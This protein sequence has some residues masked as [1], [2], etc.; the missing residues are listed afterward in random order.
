MK[1]RLKN[2]IVLIV[3]CMFVT[4]CYLIR[5]NINDVKVQEL[6]SY[7]FGL[8]HGDSGVISQ[9]KYD[10]EEIRIAYYVEGRAEG[11]VSEFAWFAFVDGLP[12]PTQLE[13]ESGEIIRQI[14]YMHQF[15]LEF[16]ERL[17][18][19]IVFTPVSG[20]NGET[21]DFIVASLLQPDYL[22]E[23][24]DEPIFGVFHTLGARFPEEIL[25]NDR[26]QNTLSNY[27]NIQLIEVPQNLIDEEHSF[28]L[29]DVSRLKW[30]PRIEILPAEADLQINYEDLI[31][32]NNG[33]VQIQ[34]LLYGGPEAVSRI[35]FFVNHQ[36][37][38]VNGV[39]FIEIQMESGQMAL[40]QVELTLTEL[41]DFNSLY[42]IVAMPNIDH[43]V[44]GI[45][46]TQT[47]L[48]VSQ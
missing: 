28:S 33:Y 13:F 26:I 5:G 11:V 46:K 21:V 38:A 35:T 48:L 42:A 24:R 20:E 29:E 47:L 34:L 23:S 7:A 30:S 10:G 45:F 8:L 40:V 16:G 3:L 27:T 6:G 43:I 19:Y 18:F 44:P 39:D 9:F 17:E 41:N 12:Q 1:V 22:P 37:V 32:A 36:P 4:G 15:G 25:I 2:F 14:D 31:V